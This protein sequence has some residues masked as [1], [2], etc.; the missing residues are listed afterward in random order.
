MLGAGD[1]CRGVGCRFYRLSRA[2]EL[3]EGLRKRGAGDESAEVY[4]L[5]AAKMTSGCPV[6]KTVNWA[7]DVLWINTETLGWKGQGERWFDDVAAKAARN[8]SGVGHG[9][10]C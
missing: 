5:A 4:G 3:V 8:D 1:R 10:D 6:C 7:V 9:K 2:E